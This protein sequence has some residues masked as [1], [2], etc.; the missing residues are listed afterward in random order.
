M[1]YQLNP[2]FRSDPIY[3]AVPGEWVGVDAP[4]GDRGPWLTAPNGST[5]WK[6]VTVNQQEQYLKVKN[7][8]RDDDWVLVQGVIAEHVL[9][10]Q[11]T[12]GGAAA[13]TYDLNGTIPAGCYFEKSLVTNITGF[14]GDTSATLIIGVTGGDTARYNTGTPSVFTTAAQGVDVGVPSGTRWHTAAA[15]PTL[16]VTSATDF[17]A[18]VAGALTVMLFYYGSAE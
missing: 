5:Y 18:V 2:T 7:D 9:Y 1:S 3:G 17:T 10:S 6:Q 12:D 4:D 8:S 15:V 11:F 13:G 16:L 14:T